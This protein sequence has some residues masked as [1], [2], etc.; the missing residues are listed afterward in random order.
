MRLVFFVA[1]VAAVP[2]IGRTT[3]QSASHIPVETMSWEK[4]VELAAANNPSLLAARQKTEAAVPGIVA[5]RAAML[6]Q[7]SVGAGAS[8]GESD[9]SPVSEDVSINLSATL[10]QNLYDGGNSR[11]ALKQKKAAL[12]RATADADD[13]AAQVTQNLRNS[14]VDLVY[15]QDN[16]LLCSEIFARRKG[17]FEIVQIRHDGGLE[18]KGALAL[19]E[20]A[21]FQAETELE[22]ARRG[23]DT[24]RQ[25]LCLTIGFTGSVAMVKADGVISTPVQV[26]EPDYKAIMSGVP[27]HVSANAAVTTAGALVDSARSAFRPKL[28]FSG[29][30]GRYGNDE[31]FGED[32]WSVGAQMR[33]PLW[34]SGRN[35]SDLKSAKANL[36]AAEASLIAV[37]NGLNADLLRTF[38]ALQD[39]IESA[40]VRQRLLAA[41]ELRAEIGREQYANGLLSF[42]NWDIIENN[43][44]A[45]R[46]SAL[47]AARSAMKAEALWQRAVGFNAFNSPGKT[48]SNR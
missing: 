16:V 1:L 47:A 39:S 37:D 27:A 10:S 28:D 12:V 32:R 41:A 29:S 18:H 23:A 2:V 35:M 48:W 33:L 3:G 45:N 21:L 7:V 31:A 43:L 19:S 11:A 38:R 20:A 14:F 22:Q 42:E 30:A 46:Q 44:I 15:A 34:T 36:A 26:K 24:A 17:N 9:S 6:P 4:C 40:A 5:A 8:H 25:T 13:T